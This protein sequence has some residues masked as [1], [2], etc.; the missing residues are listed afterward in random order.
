[1]NSQRRQRIDAAFSG[2]RDYDR[3]AGVQR[4]VARGLALRIAALDL[5]ANPRALEIGCGTGFLT[6]N[7]R[8]LQTGGEWLVTDLSTEMVERCR[9]RVGDAPGYSFAVLDGEHG[10]APQ[11]A[12]FD[13]IC[14]SLALQWF[15][16]LPAAVARLMQWLAPGGHLIFTTLAGETFAEWRAAH[17][18]EG[19]EAGTPRFPAAAVLQPDPQLIDRV[20]EHH[21]S[22]RDFL[23]S[24]KAIGAGTAAP[25]HKPLTPA[26]LRRVMARF[27]RSGANATYEVVTCHY[28]RK[29]EA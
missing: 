9:A 6:E 13:L 18:G 17:A 24:I 21:D 11:Q 29:R 14:S 1:M 7:L 28:Q 27:E 3:H 26:E 20:V 8:D 25:G 4:A 15:E 2:A 16:D 5:P 22:A 23:R 10:P 19:L 12:P